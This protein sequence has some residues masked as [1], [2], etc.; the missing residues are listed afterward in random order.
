MTAISASAIASLRARTG[1]SI[2]AVRDA[3]VE[4]N[5]DEE[6]AIEILRKRGIAQAAKKAAREQSEGKVFLAEGDGKAA[7]VLLRCETDF[8]ARGD[9]FVELG[10]QL[11]DALLAGGEAKAKELADQRVPEAVQALGENISVGDMKVVAASVLGAYVHSNSKI[12]VLIGMEGGDKELARDLAMH[13]AAANPLYVNPEE[14]TEDAVTKEKEIWKAQLQKEG[15]PEAIWDKIM[16]G[17]EKKFREENALLTQAFVKDPSKTVAQHVGA[18][19]VTG[20][21]RL[22]VA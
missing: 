11:A 8:V 15:K 6:K 19:K 14:V 7:L 17:K 10:K 3:L 1:V 16:G 18:A 5:G 9:G 22:S 21:V 4:A 12:G 2:S 20:Y 13:A